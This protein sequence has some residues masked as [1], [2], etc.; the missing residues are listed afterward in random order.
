M[1][2]KIRKKFVP[3]LPPLLLDH[4]LERGQKTPPCPGLT[5]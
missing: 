3:S 2:K 5:F 4:S 1:K